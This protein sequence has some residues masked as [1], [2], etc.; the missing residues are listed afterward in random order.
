MSIPILGLR[1]V[2]RFVK[3]YPKIAIF[4]TRM[5]KITNIC[6][7][8][9]FESIGYAFIDKLSIRAKKV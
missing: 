7:C 3:N 8:K 9:L 5:A 1:I 4:Y 2:K 6:Y